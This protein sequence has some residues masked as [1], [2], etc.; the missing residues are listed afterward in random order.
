[1]VTDGTRIA[2]VREGNIFVVSADGTDVKDLGAGEDPAWSPDGTRI[3]FQLLDESAE[4]VVYSMKTERTSSCTPTS[5]ASTAS[6][7]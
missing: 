6:M 1:V 3:A 4:Y 5:A 7:R 2:F